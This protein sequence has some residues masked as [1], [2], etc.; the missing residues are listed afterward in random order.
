MTTGVSF[1]VDEGDTGGSS[2]EKIECVPGGYI[3]VP[4]TQLQTKNLEIQ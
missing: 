4:G 1:S 2:V 3:V